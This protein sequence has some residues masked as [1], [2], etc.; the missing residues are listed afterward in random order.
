M[1]FTLHGSSPTIEKISRKASFITNS[2]TRQMNT[3]NRCK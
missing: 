3:I 1:E 2:R